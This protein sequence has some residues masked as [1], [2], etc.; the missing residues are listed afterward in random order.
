MPPNMPPRYPGFTWITV[1]Y[2]KLCEQVDQF[3]ITVLLSGGL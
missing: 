1:V 3:C 2:V